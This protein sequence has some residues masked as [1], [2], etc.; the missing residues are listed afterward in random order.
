MRRQIAEITWYLCWFFFLHFGCCYFLLIAQN[1]CQPYILYRN[2]C[3]AKSKSSALS[4]E[5]LNP[6]T[7][8]PNPQP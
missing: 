7:L 4:Q 5:T 2:F 1:R 6:E 3:T 8:N